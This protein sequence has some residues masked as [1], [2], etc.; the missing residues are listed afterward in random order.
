MTEPKRWSSPGSEVDPVLRSVLRYGR[1]LQPNAQQLQAILRGSARRRAPKRRS[2]VALVVAG[3]V[4]TCAGVAFAGYAGG[5]LFS[6]TPKPASAPAGPSAT[7]PSAGRAP[8]RVKA[9]AAPRDAVVAEPRAAESASPLAAPRPELLAS[10][11]AL[12]GA[13]PRVAS[14]TPH[15]LPEAA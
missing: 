3:A 10:P 7:S 11:S 1:D 14:S 5:F 2:F 6:P 15:S 12:D 9:Q 4:A 8:G 13:A